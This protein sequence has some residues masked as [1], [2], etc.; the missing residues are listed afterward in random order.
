M[1]HLNYHHLYYFWS[2]ANAGSV[3][4]ASDKL[5]VAQ[6]TIS[7]QLK[8]LEESLG[9]PLFVRSG[10]GLVL[11][12]A[13][14]TVHKYAEDIFN[15]GKELLQ[16][17]QGETKGSSIQMRIGVADVFP[18]LLVRNA[19]LPLF[20]ATPETKVVCYDGKPADLLSKLALHELDLVLS[21][22]PIG[23][24]VRIKAFSHLLGECQVAFMAPHSIQIKSDASFPDILSDL[25]ILLPTK[26]TAFRKMID[27]WFESKSIHPQIIGEFEDSILIKEVACAIGA[28]FAVPSVIARCVSSRFPCRCLGTIPELHVPFYAIS[29]ERKVKH[30]GVAL[31]TE[32]AKGAIFGKAEIQE[33]NDKS[34]NGHEKNGIVNSGLDKFIHC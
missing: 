26:N 13:G 10:R 5:K 32:R 18:K 6:P 19:L 11:T 25:K 27:E 23:P 4:A 33:G 31:I 21:D 8:S 24:S 12:E 34:S 20:Q 16:T 29:L 17:V 2:V 3:I 22:E 28:V 7:A 30:P 9:L 1:Q 14:K 15:L